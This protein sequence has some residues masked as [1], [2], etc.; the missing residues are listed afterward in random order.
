[1]LSFTGDSLRGLVGEFDRDEASEPVPDRPESEPSVSLISVG[2]EARMVLSLSSKVSAFVIL[3]GGVIGAGVVRLL[4]LTGSSWRME[5][6]AG[7]LSN[8]ILS[9][10]LDL[11]GTIGRR[12][13]ILS[14]S[15]FPLMLKGSTRRLGEGEEAKGGSPW[16]KVGKSKSGRCD[17]C[18]DGV[19]LD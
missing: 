12:V 11:L 6:C 17:S 8:G 10:L 5:D 4:D 7:A 16:F 1:M 15:C 13:V 3:S 14:A 2:M 18:D 9:R 19:S